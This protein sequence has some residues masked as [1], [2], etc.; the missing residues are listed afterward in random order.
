MGAS[1]GVDRRENREGGKRGQ[2]VHLGERTQWGDR[3]GPTGTESSMGRHNKGE[4][5]V[6]TPGGIKHA[7]RYSRTTAQVKEWDREALAVH[8]YIYT[9]KGPFNQ[10]LH[11][12]GRTD[13]PLCECGPVVQ[14]AAH[15]SVQ[16][17]G[18]RGEKVV[19]MQCISFHS[20]LAIPSLPSGPP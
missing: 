8:T 19:R 1:A 14:N 17:S 2:R 5:N 18:G 12:I 9:D 3:S 7:F 6:A 15:I 16:T 13:S 10:W 20:Y 11:K 4:P